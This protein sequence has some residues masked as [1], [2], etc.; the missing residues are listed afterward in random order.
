LND[1]AL[2]PKHLLQG[3]TYGK[4]SLAISGHTHI[5]CF[6]SLDVGA[7]SQVLGRK[8]DEESGGAL[9]DSDSFDH[10]AAVEYNIYLAFN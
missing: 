10:K 7:V 4:P 3:G 1:F 5:P 2:F 6:L 9:N 8:R